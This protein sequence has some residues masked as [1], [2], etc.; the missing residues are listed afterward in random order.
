VEVV[1]LPYD[2]VY[3]T[4]VPYFIE[5][6]TNAAKSTNNTVV[7][8]DTEDVHKLVNNVNNDLVVIPVDINE[9]ED[10]ITQADNKHKKLSERIIQAC[11]KVN[12]PFKMGMTRYLCDEGNFGYGSWW[13]Q[14]KE[15]KLQNIEMIR[16]YT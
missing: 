12:Q 7:E 3:A 14:I 16:H 13:S 6:I 1:F 10:D 4:E 8:L 11:R 15:E 9:L 5:Q 2:K